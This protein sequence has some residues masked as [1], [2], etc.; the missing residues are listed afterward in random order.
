MSRFNEASSLLERCLARVIPVTQ[1]NA[2]EALPQNYSVL[3]HH[4]A[5]GVGFA[6]LALIDPNPCK[7]KVSDK[8]HAQEANLHPRENVVPAICL[9]IFINALR[10]AAR[11]AEAGLESFPTPGCVQR[12]NCK[13]KNAMYAALTAFVSCFRS[14]RAIVTLL[15]REPKGWS[16]NARTTR[17]HHAGV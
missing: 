14:S 1:K 5:Y 6:G 10:I 17:V 8:T 13:E 16:S 15:R 4:S 3:R 9:R 12:L 7:L 11:A 2:L